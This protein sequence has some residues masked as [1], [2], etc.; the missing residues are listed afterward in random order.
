METNNQT[1]DI[2]EDEKEQ[3]EKQKKDNQNLNKKALV[4]GAGFGRTGTLSLK[5]ALEILGYD[6]CYHMT[7]SLDNFHIPFWE[8]VYCGEKFSWNEIFDKYKAT[9]DFPVCSYWD[10]IL[11]EYPDSKVIL[12]VRSP[13]SWYKSFDETIYSL[14][15]RLPFGVRFLRYCVP[16]FRRDS[17]TFSP[18]YLKRNL[19]EIIQKKM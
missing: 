2:K 8:R 1:N 3:Q 11:K 13:E 19:K 12:T 9:T 7:E 10:D 14:T 4:I 15:F 18:Q 16:S 17:L 6:P 5:K